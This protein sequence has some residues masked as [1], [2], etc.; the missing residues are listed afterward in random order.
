[1][2]NILENNLDTNHY[3]CSLCD[4]KSIDDKQVSANSLTAIELC[5]RHEIETETLAK[6]II[7][8]LPR[9]DK[10]CDKD[11]VI[12]TVTL[13]QS[14][15]LDEF[16]RTCALCL[17]L[18]SRDEQ[19]C[20]ICDQ[21]Y[22][23]QC[24]G[25][26]NKMCLD[27]EATH[28]QIS[29]NLHLN[30]ETLVKK[31]TS[32]RPTRCV[33]TKKNHVKLE[34]KL[35]KKEES[36]KVRELSVNEKLKER[37]KLIEYLHQLETRNIE[38]EQTIKTMN[39]NVIILEEN[40]QNHFSLRN[41]KSESVKLNSDNSDE[42]LLQ[43]RNKVTTFIV[44]RIENEL[45]KLTDNLKSYETE[46][47]GYSDSCVRCDNENQ[48]FQDTTKDNSQNVSHS[49]LIDVLALNNQLV[50]DC[51]LTS[52]SQNSQTKNYLGQNLYF[53]KE[54]HKECVE[55][56]DQTI[57]SMLDAM[58][59][60][61]AVKHAGPIRRLY[62]MTI[63]EQS[64]L[65]IDNLYTNAFS[66]VR[67]NNQISDTYLLQ[68]AKSCVIQSKSRHHEKV[69]EKVWTLGNYILLLIQQTTN[70]NSSNKTTNINKPPTLTSNKPPT[71]THPTNHQ[72]QLIQQTT[73]INSSNKPP[74]STHPTNHQHQLIQQT[75][76]INSS[77]KPPTSTH[78][79]NHQHQL[80]QQTT[81]INSFNK[82]PTSA[83][84]TN[85]QH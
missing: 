64:I 27:C 79:T 45:D 65:I 54:F 14:L 67:W 29:D 71:L 59:V 69:K 44:S 81:N 73:N 30:N 19:I 6:P 58:S 74:T 49:N 48:W 70:I 56:N 15:L 2:I 82:P 20:E 16:P 60:F 17:E 35:K 9:I 75:T 76:N 55:L 77:N 11:Q 32:P 28:S 43:V 5:N 84:P 25:K 10:N 68:P 61:D 62:Q 78:P 24:M 85:H 12:P 34:L 37:I 1:M 21:S 51:T 8:H 42:I 53:Q 13:A 3:I 50:T 36:L 83:H 38:L 40:H 18:L 4:I 31:F 41:E 22:N 57:I 63:P 47:E 46:N 52:G 80:I 7:K 39:R 33:E 66:C 72:H 26:D 23:I